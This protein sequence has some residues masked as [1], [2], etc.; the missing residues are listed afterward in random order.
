M[1]EP[2]PESSCVSRSVPCWV[3]KTVLVQSV[4]C[5]GVPAGFTDCQD[6]AHTRVGARNRQRQR[7][8]ERRM[9]DFNNIKQCSFICVHSQFWHG[10]LRI[11]ATAIGGFA[12]EFP[13]DSGYSA[14]FV[15]R[16]SF[17]SK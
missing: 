4:Y 2:P 6:W 8:G 9:G 14:N 11:D 5:G 15:I 7:M 12:D 3:S 13:Q 1:P 16:V 10:Q 17:G